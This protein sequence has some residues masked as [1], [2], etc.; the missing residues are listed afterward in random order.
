[1]AIFGNF[2]LSTSPTLKPLTLKFKAFGP[3]LTKL[4]ELRPQPTSLNPHYFAFLADFFLLCSRISFWAVNSLLN[5][6]DALSSVFV[7]QLNTIEAGSLYI[8]RR[9]S[10]KPK[11][12]TPRRMAT[13]NTQ[14][15][16]DI[17]LVIGYTVATSL[18][19]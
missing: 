18:N 6:S 17:L 3:T 8:F 13:T 15:C 12:A 5:V 4:A 7:S 11:L 16:I 10:K 1:M 9:Y 19:G 14:K 2:E